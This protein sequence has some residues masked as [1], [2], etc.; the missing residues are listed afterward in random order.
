[1]SPRYQA[2]AILNPISPRYNPRAIAYTNGRHAPW[3][4]HDDRNRNKTLSRLDNRRLKRDST[5]KQEPA[6]RNAALYSNTAISSRF[7]S[8]IILTLASLTKDRGG[9]RVAVSGT[10]EEIMIKGRS[11]PMTAAGSSG[12][13]PTAY[14]RSHLATL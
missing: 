5:P 2:E 10:K 9:C 4:E 13:T 7:S 11:E 6:H 1:V 14:T 8:P 12:S 3:P